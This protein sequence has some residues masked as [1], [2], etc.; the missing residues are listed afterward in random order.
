MCQLRSFSSC[1][2]HRMYRF[3][4]IG[5]YRTAS[6]LSLLLFGEERVSQIQYTSLRKREGECLVV[7]SEENKTLFPS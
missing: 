6:P 1:V 7:G 5:E 4:F 2:S 3:A